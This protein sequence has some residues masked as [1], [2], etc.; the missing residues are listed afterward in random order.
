VTDDDPL[1][2][3]ATSAGAAAER[4]RRNADHDVRRM[5]AFSDGVFAIAATLLVLDLTVSELGA[6]S[7]DSDLLTGLIDQSSTIIA[8]VVSFLL[9]CLLWWIHTRAFEDVVRV[10]GPFVALNSLRLLAVVLIPFTTSLS[11]TFPDLATGALYLAADFAA[12]VIIGAIQGWYATDARHGLMPDLDLRERRI[13]RRGALSAVILSLAAVVL[14]PILG[15]LAFAVYALDPL[16]SRR[17]EA[18]VGEEASGRP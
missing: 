4:E 6:I 9:L 16:L 1:L 13:I 15:T 12:V 14:A 17:L 2:S 11:S 8:F 7:T 18:G 5:E 10:D 3:A